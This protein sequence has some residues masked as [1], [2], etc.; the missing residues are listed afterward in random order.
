LGKEFALHGFLRRL[1][2]IERCIENVFT[3][4]PPHTITPPT[5]EARSD[6]TNNIQSAMFNVYGCADNLAWVWVHERN[7]TRPDGS[8]VPNG[9]V[10][11]GPDNTFVRNS[12]SERFR[13]YLEKF[14]GWFSM[15]HD[16]RHALAHRIALYIPPFI[17]DPKEENAY[18]EIDSRITDALRR[19]DH[20]EYERLRAEERALQFFRPFIMHAF[21]AKTKP[22]V[23]HPQMIAEFNSAA[24]LGEKLLSELKLTTATKS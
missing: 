23:F 20:A 10:G 18:R 13:L 19:L 1:K 4:I 9:W 15:L 22:L 24:D 5:D 17:I 6:A 21:S 7:L 14:D 2:T 11:L 16:Y 3:A 12:F 8:A